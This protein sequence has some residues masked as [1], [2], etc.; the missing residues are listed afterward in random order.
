MAAVDEGFEDVL[1]DV[2]VVVDD[3]PHLLTKL[4]EMLDGFLHAVIRDVVGGGLGTQGKMVPD[5]LLGKTMLSLLKTP[6]SLR[7]LM[8]WP[9]ATM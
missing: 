4:G 3:G 8:F 5:V 1:L 9:N 6:F 2:Q 7:L